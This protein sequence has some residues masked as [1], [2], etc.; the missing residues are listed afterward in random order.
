MSDDVLSGL[1]PYAR[2]LII[3]FL[4]M[5]ADRE[6]RLE[7][8]PKKIWAESFP[9]EPHVDIDQLLTELFDYGYINRYRVE[10]KN[11]IQIN[12]FESTQKPHGT[13]KDSLIP[14]PEGILTIHV[15]SPNGY[16]TGKT[17]RASWI[18][19]NEQSTNKEGTV[20]QHSPNALIPDSGF[21]NTD[22]LKTDIRPACEAS[23]AVWSLLTE[24]QIE[25]ANPKDPLLQTVINNECPVELWREAIEIAQRN[26]N[27]NFKYICGIFQN[28][29]RRVGQASKNFVV[30]NTISTKEEMQARAEKVGLGRWQEEGKYRYEHWPNYCARVKAAEA[31]HSRGVQ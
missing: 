19:V 2:L 18:T 1:S 17:Y 6:G 29:L 9:Y 14:D 24:Y 30:Q 28:K 23:K 25:N 5:L 15:R 10:T 26:G 4:P 3:A 12:D 20:S 31:N 8:R 7:D 22:L 11:Y 27:P 16:A 21:L 13:E